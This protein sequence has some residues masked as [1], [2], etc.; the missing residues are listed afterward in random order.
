[1]RVLLTYYTY[2]PFANG[3]SR[4]LGEMSKAFT[5]KNHYV[6]IVSGG[7]EKSSIEKRGKLRIHRLS[8]YNRLDT[9]LSGEEISKKFLAYLISIHKKRPLDIIEAEGLI[10]QSDMPYSIALN[11]FSIM[12]NVPI[13]LRF[14]GSGLTE[15]SK[16]LAKNLFWKKIFCVCQKGAEEMHKAKI[17]VERLATQH[18]GINLNKFKKHENK[19]WLRS[20]VNFSD[21]DFVIGTA[22]RIISALP[23]F[24]DDEDTEIEEKGI[25]DLIKAFANAF[26]DNKEAKLVIAAASPPFDLQNRFNI[27]IKKLEDLSKLLKIENRVVIKSFSMEEMPL[28]YNGLDLF[29]LPS[30][31]EAYPMSI[32]EAMACKIP[33]VATSVGG[34]PEIISNEE[35]G[36]LVPVKDHV[37]LAKVLKELEKNPLKRKEAAEKAYKNLTENNRIERVAEGIIGSYNSVIANKQKIIKKEEKIPPDLSR[38]SKRFNF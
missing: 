31:A 16:T 10:N 25:I 12:Y 7:V 15:T 26:N 2:P 29:A 4:F 6:E 27:A 11:M 38:L 32:I 3:V 19:K 21:K 33:V 23:L 24:S 18:N 28:F 5:D 9:S 30:C 17:C 35:S 8:F 34:I 20:R 14:H 22:S 37:S 36:F 13:V 1:M